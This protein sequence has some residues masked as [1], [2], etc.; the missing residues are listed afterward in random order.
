M[1]KILGVILTASMVMSS[2]TPVLA[3]EQNKINVDTIKGVDRYK[4]SAKISQQTFPNHIKTVVLASGENFADSL[5]AGSLANKKKAPVLLTQKEKLPQ[6]IKDEITRLKPEEVIIVGGEKSVNIKGLKNVKR[7]AG[8]DRFETS[9]EVYKHVNPNG[10]VALASGLN[11][12]DA[13]CATPLS[14]KENLPI[15]LTDG[16]NLPKGIT[17]DKVALIF[18]GEKSVNIKGLENARRLAGADRYETALIIAK[19]FG[20]LEKFVLAD[21]RNY[22]DALS[23]GP[24]AHKNNQPILLTDPSHT[25]FIKQI[26]RDNN[27]KEITVVGGEQSISKA[28]IETIKSVGVIEDKKPD[29]PSVTPTP[30]IPSTPNI[31]NKPEEKPEENKPEDKPEEKPEEN[32]PEEKPEEKPGENKPGDKP[33]EK[34]GEEK[35]EDKPGDKP[36]DKPE[37]KPEDIAKE[38]ALKEAKEKA[39]EELKNNGIT[40]PVYIDQI[41]KAKTV[42]GVNA[43]K[44]EIIKAHKKSEE[45]KPEYVDIEDAKLLKVLNKNL[46]VNRPDDKPITKQEM[47]SLKEVSIFIDKKTNKPIFTEES[48]NTYSILGKAQ[49]LSKTKDFKFSVTRGMKSLKGIEYATNLEKLKVNENEISDL[50]P[51]EDLKNLKYLELQRNRIVDVSPLANLKNLEFLK[52]YNNIIENVEPLKDLTNLTGLDLHNNVKVKK[53]GQKKIN[54]DGITDISS[55]KNLTKLTFFDVSANRIENVDI[56]LGMEKINSLDFSDNKIKD[57]S[58]LINYILPRFMKQQEGEA[59][60]GFHGQNVEQKQSVTVDKNKVSFSPEYKGLGNLFN[61]FGKAFEMEDVSE[62][63]NVTTNV[64]GVTATFDVKNDKINLEVTDE[65]LKSNDGKT[66]NVNLKVVFA[67][68]YGWNLNDVKLQVKKPAE[69]P[70]THILTLVGDNMSSNQ[71]SDKIKKGT[72]VVITFKPEEK[73]FVTKL[74]V[75]GK[76]EVTK[77]KDNKYTFIMN[78]DTKIEPTYEKRCEL[79][80]KGENIKSSVKPSN[81][82]KPGTRIKITV[83]PDDDKAVS[84]FLVNGQNL[85]TQLLNNTYEFYLDK[86][87]TIEVKYTQKSTEPNDANDFGFDATTGTIID[88]KPYARKDV[89]I[90]EKINGV[91]VKHIAEYAFYNKGL[92][93]V[94]IPN[95]VI[96]IGDLAFN[97]NN[98]GKVT[99]PESVEEIGSGAFKSA[100][101]IKVTLPKNIKK[102]GKGAFANN[103]LKEFTVP[104]NITSIPESLVENNILESLE[105]P[106]TVSEIGAKAFKSNELSGVKFA[107]T[108]KKIDILAFADNNIKKVELAKDCDVH[109]LAFDSS[110]ETNLPKK[111]EKEVSEEKDFVFDKNTQTITEYIGTDLVVKIPR[112]IG[113]VDV[114][115]IGGFE[116]Y[117]GIKKIKV[118]AFQD[119][120]IMKLTIPEGVETIDDS[121]FKN[122]IIKEVVLPQSLNKIGKEAFSD[123]KLETITIPKNVSRIEDGTFRNNNLSSVK[124]EGKVKYIGSECFMNNKLQN[125]DLPEGLQSIKDGSFSGNFLTEIKIPES[126]TEIETGAFYGNQ[127]QAL[128]ISKN[129]KKIGD[130]AFGYCRIKELLVPENVEVI[131]KQAFIQNPIEKAEFKGATKILF[132]A[133]YTCGLNEVKFAD[134]TDI[135]VQSFQNNNL[136]SVVIPK[137][138]KKLAAQAFAQNF[139]ENVELPEGLETIGQGSLYVNHLVNVKIPS[140]VKTIEDA[141]F[142]NNKIEKLD[143]GLNVKTIGEGAFKKNNLKEVTVSKDAQLGKEAF[144]QTVKIIKN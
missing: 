135:G 42:E 123:N 89:I 115:A 32:K 3:E 74:L 66:V 12:A 143:I 20:N 82:I 94:K 122:N 130:G 72:E 81:Q 111:P 144:D 110:V 21:G 87:T 142:F 35:P 13:L 127:I 67:E 120:G 53:E 55:L 131:G 84:E 137:N 141:A 93:S 140:T 58:K 83:D 65:F 96:S 88:Y 119:K 28:Q 16:H 109:P 139:L 107:D 116:D 17:K 105:I 128:N 97:G 99:I 2:F 44:D 118:G 34:P 73:H 69:K 114:K 38:K 36:G 23:V 91:E 5:V 70:E 40:S 121:A 92:N 85:I 1:K 124:M 15:I 29:T 136:K 47:E 126:V 10:K 78:E 45:D 61:E 106:N 54:Y 102:I 24:L 112:Q 134:D 95:T 39:V 101:L 86:C 30:N 50:T 80:L 133:F 76:D 14:T 57:Y 77:I 104:K 52:L 18:G 8:K 59:S 98:L 125:I 113:G 49:D 27:T 41:N 129:L 51:L 71:A 19:E 64:E 100:G 11:F 6:V 103:K 108:V 31:P 9:V 117:F 75:N 63:V 56:I 68:A 132:Q 25:E 37:E 79:I 90:P 46:D 43:L 62:V 138:T 33:E 48:K 22:P 60:V 26:V 4:T 7:L